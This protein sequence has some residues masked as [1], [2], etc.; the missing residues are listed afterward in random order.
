VGTADDN[1]SFQFAF[2]ELVVAL[3]PSGL[4]IPKR[5]LTEFPSAVL[6]SLKTTSSCLSSGLSGISFHLFYLQLDG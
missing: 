4:D 1:G 5:S 3:A 6:L 2:R